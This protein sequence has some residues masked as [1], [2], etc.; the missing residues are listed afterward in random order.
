MK[1]NTSTRLPILGSANGDDAALA[2][3]EREDGIQ[4]EFGDRHAKL[5]VESTILKGQ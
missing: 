2:R 3:R 5:Y 1:Q 4:I